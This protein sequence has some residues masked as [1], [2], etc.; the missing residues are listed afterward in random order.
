[1]PSSPGDT[2]SSQ[3]WLEKERLLLVRL[4]DP[5]HLVEIEALFERAMDS[6][7]SS[8]WLDDTG[9]WTRH[10]VDEHGVHLDDMQNRLMALTGHIAAQ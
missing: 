6:R 5:E 1:M 10:D 8:W 4:I 3:F 9:Q 7:T 2:T